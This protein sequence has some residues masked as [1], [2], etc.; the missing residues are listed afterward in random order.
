MRIQHNGEQPLM[1]Y[2]L[3]EG[4]GSNT[5]SIEFRLIPTRRLYEP[6]YSRHIKVRVKINAILLRL[7][8]PLRTRMK[9]TI[10]ELSFAVW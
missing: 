10:S 8:Q 1:I 4:P 3:R 7:C 6:A 5:G 9:I 2:K